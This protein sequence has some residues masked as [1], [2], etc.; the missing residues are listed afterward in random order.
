LLKLRLLN[1][2]HSTVAYLAAL[3]GYGLVDRVVKDQDFALYLRR[4]LDEEASPVLPHVS[5]IDVEDYK[6]TLIKRFSNPA[7]RDQVSRICLDGS[8][9]FPVF[10]IPTIAA[11]VVASGPTR[12][13]ALALAGWCQ[14]LLGTDDNG[15]ELDIAADPGLEA[16]TSFA[17]ASMDEPAAF[18]EFAKVFPR[19][20][21]SQ[22]GF[23][24]EFT[25]AL[26][27]LRAKGAQATV[28]SWARS[29][30]T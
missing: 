25:G 10:L 20:L 24:A 16:A 27:S 5:G 23:R 1:A 7:I 8:S 15:H 12:L 9:K 21:A 4:F 17:R 22:P 30:P 29:D 28:A 2:G 3:A 13:A 11:Q 6:R 26:Q 14:Y 19:D 18:L